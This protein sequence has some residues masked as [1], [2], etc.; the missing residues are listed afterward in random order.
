MKR[1]FLKTCVICEKQFYALR[2]RQKACSTMCMAKLSREFNKVNYWKNIKY[3]HARG[4]IKCL[5]EKLDVL[6]VYSNGTMKCK[7]C[8]FDDVASLS[9]DHINNNGGKHRKKINSGTTYDWLVRNNFPGINTEYQV[10]C[11]NCQFIKKTNG[12]KFPDDKK[13]KQIYRRHN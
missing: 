2:Q 9:I 8:G 5:Q 3:Q 12:G 4:Q 10:L 7:H 13:I 11:M 1:N 6:Q